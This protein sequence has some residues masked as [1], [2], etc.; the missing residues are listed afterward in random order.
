MT[1][2]EGL[3]AVS[4]PGTS[5]AGQGAE[6]TGETDFADMLQRVQFAGDADGVSGVPASN[7]PAA[8]DGSGV[9]NTDAATEVSAGERAEAR[10]ITVRASE[11][12]IS[13]RV[14]G[15]IETLN[16][17]RLLEMGRRPDE[18]PPT[19][20]FIGADAR[21]DGPLAT[22]GRPAAPDSAMDAAMSNLRSAFHHAIEVEMVAK[23]GSS[24]N[25]SMNKLMSGN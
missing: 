12:S 8:G 17:S 5:P 24:L 22:L 3:A 2:I 13:E 9:S 19:A 1:S 11:P 14:G 4:G 20:S 7:Q 6:R 18:G 25:S 23:T 21:A 15:K 16:D 10:T